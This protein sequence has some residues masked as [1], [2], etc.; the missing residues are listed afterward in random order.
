L[1]TRSLAISAFALI[2]GS[3]AA[4]PTAGAG[5]VAHAPVFRFPPA[6]L[7]GQ[8][9]GGDGPMTNIRSTN[10]AGYVDHGRSFSYTRASW[11]V[12]PLTCSSDD[13]V[14]SFWVGVDGYHSKTVEQAG[15]VG[16]CHGGKPTY[17]TWWEMFPTNDAQLVGSSVR[18]GD[19]I[20][21]S[22]SVSGS[23]Y[24]LRVI[25]STHPANSFTKIATCSA[26][27]NASVEWIAERPRH[28]QGL[29]PLARFGHLT[30]MESRVGSNGVR[31]SVSKYLHD[32][33]TMINHNGA[34]LARVS[35]LQRGGNRFVATWLRGQ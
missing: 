13:S 11:V 22:V 28:Q 29:Y 14:A 21:A 9:R 1:I 15:T 33:V 18:A 16:Y 23:K 3:L 20:T 7:V 12:S 24:T 8:S 35:G 2:A 6:H 19:E 17:Y 31:G 32:A 30:F 26:C 10:W 5:P 27:R 25:D 4:A 34:T